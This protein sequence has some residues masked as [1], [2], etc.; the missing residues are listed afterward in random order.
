[1]RFSL[2]DLSVE[3][4]ERVDELMES[5]K[6]GN[7]SADEHEK[8]VK[9]LGKI[10]HDHEQDYFTDL[11]ID[12]KEAYNRWQN[13]QGAPTSY[14]YGQ[15]GMELGYLENCLVH[16]ERIIEEESK[17]DPNY[18]RST[19][20]PIISE[21]S[22]I[23]DAI[24]YLESIESELKNA[25]G[26]QVQNATP[27]PSATD[28]LQSA[29]QQALLPEIL[30]VPTETKKTL[31][32]LA[33]KDKIVWSSKNKFFILRSSYAGAKIELEYLITSKQV[34]Y[35]LLANAVSFLIENVKSKA[36]NSLKNSNKTLDYNKRNKS[37]KKNGKK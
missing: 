10:L 23:Y 14:F 17:L 37:G 11:I 16:N 12:Y 2:K 21:T 5:V 18:D 4:R 9:E 29:G 30:D 33:E 22:H 25:M 34:K 20:N 8:K 26:Q 15:V 28:S 32:L 27:Q 1:M 36:G 31:D 6:N 7:L 3:E 24:R 35:P 13:K 19:D